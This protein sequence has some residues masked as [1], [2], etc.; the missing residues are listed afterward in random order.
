MPSR[1]YVHDRDR[2][3]RITHVKQRIESVRT[4]RL[5]VSSRGK[6]R[7]RNFLQ[8]VGRTLVRSAA[9]TELAR[10]TNPGSS[11]SFATTCSPPSAFQLP[12]A[13]CATSEYLCHHPASVPTLPNPRRPNEP[14]RNE[15][16]FTTRQRVLRPFSSPPPSP[17]P[18]PPTCP[19]PRLN[20][21]SSTRQ[22]HLTNILFLCK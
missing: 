22:I 14:F 11:C 15:N 19:P 7:A 2:R 4:H 5:A 17:L 8:Q 10:Q 1:S 9:R 16:C 21:P 18:S 20:Q 12:R 13:R 6:P 3:V